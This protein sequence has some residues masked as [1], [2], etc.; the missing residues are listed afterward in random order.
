[1]RILFPLFAA[2]VFAITTHAQAAQPTRT[3][4]TMEQRFEKANAT[5]DGRLTLEQANTGYKSVA[6]HFSAIDKDTKGYVTEDDIRAYYK[7]QRAL[8]RQ[9]SPE[10]Q[11]T[12]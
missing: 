11:Q 8:H 6:R 12:N 5:H 10:S 2:T 7:T 1:M 4:L 9:S 3:H